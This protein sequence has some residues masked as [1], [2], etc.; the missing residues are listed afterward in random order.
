[1]TRWVLLML[2][3]TAMLVIPYWLKKSSDS[4]EKQRAATEAKANGLS[5]DKNSVVPTAAAPPTAGP[6]AR[7]IGYGLTFAK[8]AA[9]ADTP[10][11]YSVLTCHGDP[12][13]TDKPN[14]G[15]CNPYQGDTFCRVVLPVLCLKQANTGGEFA[16]FELATTEPVMG[17]LL[18]SE[19]IGTARCEKELGSGWRMAD[20][21]AGGGWSMSGKTGKGLIVS[22]SRF[23]VA[24]KDQPGNCWDSQP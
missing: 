23:W 16:P 22:S 9:A 18:E 13:P 12:K 8:G 24:I 17:A 4:K 7:Q 14:K 6:G 3:L 10:A 5:D 15:S 11:D 21:H 1:M 20:F 19:A 2:I